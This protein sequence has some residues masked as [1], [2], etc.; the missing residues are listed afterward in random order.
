MKKKEKK[1]TIC[2]TLDIIKKNVFNILL[3]VK[4]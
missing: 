1:K 2:G 3:T 4:L